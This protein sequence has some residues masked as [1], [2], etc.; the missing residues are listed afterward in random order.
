MRRAAAYNVKDKNEVMWDM[1]MRN[2]HECVLDTNIVF[3]SM[4]I[5]ATI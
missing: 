1:K 4:F 2:R 3:F 5:Y